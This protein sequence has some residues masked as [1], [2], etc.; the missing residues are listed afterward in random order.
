RQ[1]QRKLKAITNKS[2][3]QLISS[4][5][6]HRAKELIL[7]NNYNIAEI[8]YR[9]GFSSPSYFSKCFKKEFG[10]SPSSLLEK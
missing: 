4:V 10:H 2:P 3:I 7:G 8:S 6:L 1:L 9:T 5:R